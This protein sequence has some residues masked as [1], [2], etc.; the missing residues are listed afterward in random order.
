MHNAVLATDANK[1][2]TYSQAMKQLDAKK[3]VE[4]IL[5]EVE[6]HESQGHWMIVPR[7]SLSSGAKTICAIWSF[8]CKKFP[9]SRLDKHN[10]RLCAQGG[11]QQWG[12]HY[13]ETDSPVVNMLCVRLC[14]RF[15]HFM[16][17]SPN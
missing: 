1:N 14:W 2:Y 10:V 12:E 13:W 16:A 11:M 6:A 4:V 7:S 9:D 8:K 3:F 5:I 17:L 15:P